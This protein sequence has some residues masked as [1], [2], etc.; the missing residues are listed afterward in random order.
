MEDVVRAERQEDR[1]L[2]TGSAEDKLTPEQFDRVHAPSDTDEQWPTG[3]YKLAERGPS[4]PCKP[5]YHRYFLHDDGH[6]SMMFERVDDERID[7][8]RMIVVSSRRPTRIVRELSGD[9][10]VADLGPDVDT[11]AVESAF[12]MLRAEKALREAR[13]AT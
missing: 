2:T 13:T 5:V 1:V 9:E 3:T 11:G 12:A 8:V 10:D 6:V 4:K 7:F